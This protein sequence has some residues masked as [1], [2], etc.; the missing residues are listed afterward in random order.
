MINSEPNGPLVFY[1][2]HPDSTLLPKICENSN[3]LDLPLQHDVYMEPHELKKINLGIQFQL[4]IHY[5][6]LLLNKSSARTKFCVNVQLGL[7]DVNYHDYIILVVQNM[8]NEP[9]ILPK[10]IALAQL[11][12][13]PNQIPQFEL[14]WPLTNSSRQ[15][16]G[17]TGQNFETLSKNQF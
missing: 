4:P 12:I 5:C 15:G 2:L 6:A 16:F 1:N 8:T 3:G 17:S 7:I 11:L 10:G 14:N 13:I 9:L